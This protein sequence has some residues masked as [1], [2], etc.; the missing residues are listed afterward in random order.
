MN[1]KQ[2]KADL[3]K[4]KAMR[5]IWAGAAAACFVAL[6][7][8]IVFSSRYIFDCIT[9]EQ[10]VHFEEKNKVSYLIHLNDEDGFYSSETINGQYKEYA[11]A[12][13][14]YIEVKTCYAANLDK[15]VEMA[16]TAK[17]TVTL[18]ARE[19]RA[20]S[21]PIWRETTD[22]GL[23]EGK[24]GDGEIKVEGSFDL[25]LEEYEARLAAFAKTVGFK[26]IGEIT[27]TAEY[28]LISKDKTIATPVY[29]RGMSIQLNND[30]YTISLSGKDSIEAF[31]PERKVH[32]PALWISILIV[33]GILATLIPMIVFLKLA[34]RDP[35]LYR[36]VINGIFRKYAGE[37]AEVSTEPIFDGLRTVEVNKIDE[38]LKFAF[39]IGKPVVAYGF[40]DF[41][42]FFIICDNYAYRY[43]V[44][45]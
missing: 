10:T 40:E 43:V 8:I 22:L 23:K 19:S 11:R 27:F 18:S 42:V 12:Y 39:N 9:A 24:F 21:S 4:Q 35:D 13:T 3:Q 32:M 45:K 2:T 14:D 44:H 37:V 29:A 36:R 34:L 20:G 5:K 28:K 6:A 26:I 17:Y 30:P 15:N 33:A 16:Y 38:L 25:R 7:L 41:T 1:A 31:I